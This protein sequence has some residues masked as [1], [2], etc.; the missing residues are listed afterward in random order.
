MME[1]HLTGQMRISQLFL[2]VTFCCGIN[3][4]PYSI[5]IKA[6]FYDEKKFCK[7]MSILIAD[8]C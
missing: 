3:Q 4:I 5:T 7:R 6:L 8:E 2:S 1:L